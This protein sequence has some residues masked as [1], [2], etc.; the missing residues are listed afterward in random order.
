MAG[1]GFIGCGNMGGALATAVAKAMGPTSVMISNRTR[2]KAEALAGVLGARAATNEEVCYEA[3]F[4]FLGV[5]PQMMSALGAQI[6]NILKNRTRRY[7]LVSMAAGLSIEDIKKMTCKDAPVIRIS[8]NTPVA[9][10]EGTV[11]YTCSY[12]VKE[13]EKAIFLQAL[14]KCGLV[15]DIPEHLHPIGGTLSG[16]SPAFV[17]M[18][19]E[20]LADGA[21]ACGL[22]RDAAY[23]IVGQMLVGTGRL[24]MESGK[25]PG[26]LKDEVCSP[27][28]STI[29]G[30]RKLEEN[31]FRGTVMDAVIASYEKC[32][33]MTK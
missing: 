5:K 24:L 19:A 13:E 7:V 20:A 14:S 8:P 29:Q 18:F 10:G 2:A 1:F 15:R 4:I 31:G 23:E 30:V 12:D 25:H 26:K 6:D 3:D 33:N 21:V 9:I 27:A 17:D 28:G 32:I 16:C 11:L 22:M